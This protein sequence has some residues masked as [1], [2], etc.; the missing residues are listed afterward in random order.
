[1][2]IDTKKTFVNLLA[3]VKKT[4]NYWKIFSLS[5]SGKIMIVKSLVFPIV[6]YYLS[7]LPPPQAWLSDFEN[8]ISDF[9]LNRMNVSRDKCFADPQEGGLGLFKPLIFFKS[10]TCSW[11]KRCS[12]LAHDNWRRIITGS[13]GASMLDKIIPTDVAECGPLI[14]HIVKNFSE[15][16][17]LFGISYN[18]YIFSPII[19]NVHFFFKERGEKTVYTNNFFGIDNVNIAARQLCWNDLAD[20]GTGRLK[21]INHLNTYLGYNL[22][23]DSYNKLTFGFRNARAK[24]EERNAASMT[25]HDFFA[26]KSKGSKVFRKIFEIGNKKKIGL[27]RLTPGHRFLAISG[28]DEFRSDCI[29][30]LQ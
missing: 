20:T 22:T 3:K 12:Q 16:R 19:N 10:L 2:K 28:L 6:N 13:I 30:N 8:I 21:S 26:R 29:N 4:I 7:I 9:V 11:I 18:N 5:V 1:M 27:P 14:K 15:L 23:A 25:F 24:Y 17:D